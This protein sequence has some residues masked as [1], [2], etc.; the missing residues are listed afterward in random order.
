MNIR[1]IVSIIAASLVCF[2]AIADEGMWCINAINSALEKK[3][4]ERGLRLKANQIYDIDAEGAT[5]ADA[6]VSLDFGCT[7]SIISEQGLLITNHH[8][9]YSDVHSL[10]TDEHNYLENGFYAPTM[11]DE[12]N[13]K[14]KGAFFL[15]QLIDVTEETD[16][17][18]D[19]LKAAGQ[20]FGM[21][22]LSHL[23]EKRYSKDGL[24]A[25]FYSMWSGS[26]FYIA[27]YKVYK[28]VRLVV[29][30]PVSVAA[31]G[32]DIDN[33]EWPQHKCDFAMYRIYTAPD[34]SPAEYSPFNVPMI[35]EGKLKISTKGYKKGDYT[36]VIGYPGRTSRYSSSA[37]VRIEQE[38]KHPISN[39]LRG[40]QMSIINE[41][42]NC[43]PKVRLLY[44]NYYFSLSN[45]QELYCGQVDCIDRFGVI[46]IKEQEEKELAE[47]IERC[48]PAENGLLNA[49]SST[50]ENTRDVQR[51][52]CYFRETIVRGTRLNRIINCVANLR[53]DV[54]KKQGIRSRR[55]LDK[56][57][58]EGQEKCYKEY[59]FVGKDFDKFASKLDK[60]YSVIDLR[61]EKELFN[62][63]LREFYS[64]VDREFWG[65]YQKQLADEFGTDKEGCDAICN[66][67][68]NN[69]FLTDYS[70]RDAF[71]SES[72]TCCDYCSDPLVRFFKDANIQVFN[73][74][75][76]NAQGK[77]RT[78]ELDKRY[79]RSMY[80][81]KMDK[82]C[83]QYPDANSSMRITYG[84]VGDLHAKDAVCCSYQSTVKGIL[85][86]YRP[87]VYDFTLKPELPALYKEIQ[88]MPVD[89]LCDCDITGGNSGSP[90]L[91]A[92]G[93]LI[94]LAFDGNKESLASDVS[95]TPGYNKC[96]C[97]DIRFVL[98]T[99]RNF[100][101]A[102]RILDEL[103]K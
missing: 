29:A 37:K 103:G 16:A 22:R 87:A 61:V 45:V 27:L 74:A 46:G 25:G 59:C 21:R 69:S 82:G 73:K 2:N 80:K 11:A 17:L 47:W 9:A 49:L 42:M 75:L 78:N 20:P 15:K 55:G 83:L 51:N 95:Y 100:I 60:E 50:Y 63:A 3:M 88:D 67:V 84:T 1:R 56:G 32:G 8:C 92:R 93:E 26:K 4:R 94:G 65:P 41:W 58:V 43:D 28:D 5:I 89:F 52:S 77:E 101:G 14:G 39:K 34:G 48:L 66:I 62:F 86:K 12:V 54:E 102:E 97:V 53:G 31:F 81:M 72:H 7:G 30:P 44:S 57:D 91:N 64:N 18:R 98:W 40:E 68:W 76:D 38:V 96:V 6:V 85:E 33:W 10:S 24:T 19:E 36:M 23:M 79:T 70:R 71:L 99:L 13:I 35:A 90:V